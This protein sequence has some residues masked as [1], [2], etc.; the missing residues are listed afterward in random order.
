MKWFDTNS[1]SKSEKRELAIYDC[2]LESHLDVLKFPKRFPKMSNIVLFTMIVTVFN[3]VEE[4]I[5][6]IK[7][8]RNKTFEDKMK[9]S[10]SDL[11]KFALIYKIQ[12]FTHFM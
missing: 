5:S 8:A 2:S 12:S 4:A 1:N 10:T 9:L 3:P 11:I 7:R 6:L